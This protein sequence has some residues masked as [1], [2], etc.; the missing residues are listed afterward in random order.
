[1]FHSILLQAHTNLLAVVDTAQHAATGIVSPAGAPVPVVPVQ[2]TTTPLSFVMQGG[3][4][5][6]PLIFFLLLAIYFTIERFVV[7]AKARQMDS[8]FM[9]NIKNY[10]HDGKVDAARE[11]CRAQNTPVSR[12]IEK[13]ISRLGKPTRDISEAMETAGR[14]EVSRIDKNLHFLSLTSRLAPML[15]LIGT[16]AGVIAIFHDITL[17]GDIS[18]RTIS[19]G[20][21]QKMISSGSGLIIGAF[22]FLS[23]HLLNTMADR[24]SI[25]IETSCMEFLDMINEPG[26]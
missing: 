26:K 5:M 1:M 22:A 19:G 15:G 7:L 18:I 8:N 12:V 25:K 13:G 23:Y 3:W 9:M 21:Q 20:L 4:V 24:V 14:F 10:L 2:E 11:F 16:I 17:S 6:Y